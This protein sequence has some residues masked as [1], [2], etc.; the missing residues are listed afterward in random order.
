MKI[1]ENSDEEWDDCDDDSVVSFGEA[2]SEDP[3]ENPF[4]P[5]QQKIRAKLD[6]CSVRSQF[7]PKVT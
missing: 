2:G 7:K 6:Q 5:A 1:D 4:D 3:V